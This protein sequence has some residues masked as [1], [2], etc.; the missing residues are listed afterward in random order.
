MLNAKGG[1]GKRTMEVNLA[2]QFRQK[3]KFI[4]IDADIQASPSYWAG[5]NYN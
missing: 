2:A 1:L 4:L 5:R 3:N